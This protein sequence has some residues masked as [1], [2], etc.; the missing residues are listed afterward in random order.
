MDQ[1]AAINEILEVVT[2][3]KDNAVMKDDFLGLKK[4]VAGMKATMVTKDYLD[5]KLADLR[6]DLVVL[7]RK[8]DTKLKSL[9]KLLKS[10]KVISD[11]DE[12]KLLNMEPF[13]EI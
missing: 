3:I 2:F 13:A 8:E 12:Q 5:E 6:G 7:A 1:Q 10:K 11:S 9:I 4:E